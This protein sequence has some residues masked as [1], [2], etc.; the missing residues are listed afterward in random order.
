LIVTEGLQ[1]FKL[2]VAALG[3]AVHL[4]MKILEKHF[5]IMAERVNEDE[6]QAGLAG[7]EE[8]HINALV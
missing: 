6:K 8:F 4:I 3:A 1:S 2:H 5:L 7:R